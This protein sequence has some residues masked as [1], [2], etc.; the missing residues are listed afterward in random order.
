MYISI[1]HVSFYSPP[2]GQYPPIKF[3]LN[4]SDINSIIENQEVPPL[5]Y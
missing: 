1:S 5:G 4:I 2:S 3:S